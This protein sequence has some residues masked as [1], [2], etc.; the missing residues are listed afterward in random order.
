MTSIRRLEQRIGRLEDD[1]EDGSD[2]LAEAIRRYHEE[3]ST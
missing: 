3:H 2:T 1:S